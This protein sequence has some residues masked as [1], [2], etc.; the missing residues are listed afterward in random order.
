MKLLGELLRAVELHFDLDL[1]LDSPK[2]RQPRPPLSTAP[3]KASAIEVDENTQFLV[4]ADSRG[5]VSVLGLSSA[6]ESKLDFED[7]NGLSLALSESRP[8]ATASRWGPK[9]LPEDRPGHPPAKCLDPKEVRIATS[10]IPPEMKADV[11]TF[12]LKFAIKNMHTSASMTHLVTFG[13]LDA[14]K[15]TRYC[16]R[17]FKVMY[18][19]VNGIPIIDYRWI[20]ECMISGK[21]VDPEAF[22]LLR[23]R[24]SER[25]ISRSRKEVA[26]TEQGFKDFFRD[27][28]FSIVRTKKTGAKFKEPEIRS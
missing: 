16:A 2:A 23:D 18:S 21:I 22:R 24:V 6:A 28:S 5:K 25:G 15:K 3:S 4:E 19:I 14:D 12:R 27:M 8:V 11:N 7:T 17:T 10:G 1:P 13:C 9:P 20:R 26:W